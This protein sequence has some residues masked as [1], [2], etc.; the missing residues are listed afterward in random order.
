MFARTFQALTITGI[1]LVIPILNSAAY[2]QVESKNQTTGGKRGWH[3]DGFIEARGLSESSGL[4]RSARHPGIFWSHN[5]SGHGPAL[6]AMT[7]TGKHVAEIQVNAPA[8][9]D[10]EDIAAD[11]KGTLFIGDIGDN[12]ANR[13]RYQVFELEE[14]NPLQKP[15]AVAPV[16][17][18]WTYML[19]VGQVD[20]E[21]LFYHEGDL[22]VITKEIHQLP[23]IFRLNR[24]SD[25]T[26]TAVAVSNINLPMIT[27]ADVSPDG[28]LLAVIN[29][30]QLAVY[31]LQ[32]GVASV[33]M[34]EPKRVGFPAL[35]QAEACVFDSD[36]VIV[37]SESRGIWRFTDREIRTQSL[38][39]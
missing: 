26:A 36:D 19:P 29:Y 33:G 5:D 14:P 32:D 28:R 24:N 21:A 15:L 1:G 12:G 10:W 9:E 38:E 27:S 11:G 8:C 20:A 6:F 34:Q 35:V 25:G 22:Y 39:E 37:G 30:T 4:A 31:S 7:A 23:T 17:R 2:G 18:V 16:R 13:S 3:T